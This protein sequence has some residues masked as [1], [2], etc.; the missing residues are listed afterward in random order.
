MI[1]S[2][3]VETI[4]GWQFRVYLWCSDSNYTLHFIIGKHQVGKNPVV[5]SVPGVSLTVCAELHC[6]DCL[7]V[8]TGNHRT[9]TYVQAQSE[10]IQLFFT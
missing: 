7:Y 5:Y 3:K 2:P 4:G 10:V 8:G 1:A 9:V 6:H